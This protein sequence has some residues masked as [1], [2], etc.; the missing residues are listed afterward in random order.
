[1]KA[2][3]KVGFLV[4][5]FSFTSSIHAQKSATVTSTNL[6]AE[7]T[8]S[9]TSPKFAIEAGYINPVRYGSGVS[10]TYFN[11]GRLGLTANY[12]LKNNFSLLT[13]VLYSVV[14]SNK[15]QGY[16]NSAFV[17]YKTLGHFLDIPLRAT[18]N[19]PISKTLK[20]FAF[21]G[22]NLNIGLYQK[23]DITSTQTYLATDPLFIEPNTIDFYKESILNRLNLQI[24]VGGGV[25]WKHLQLKSGYDFGINNLHK[26]DTGN[27]YQKGWYVTFSY[28]F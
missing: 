24:G 18:Y 5:F 8:N 17:T 19:L 26:V 12:D 20:V 4:L 7:K 11:G 28:E 27:L 3:F 22:P 6:S 14:Y 25:Q 1:M 21:A 23:Q 2:V 16:P 10:S 15:Q 13:G 9:K